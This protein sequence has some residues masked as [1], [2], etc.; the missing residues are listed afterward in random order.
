MK[1]SSFLFLALVLT[2]S[3]AAQQQLTLS[4][5]IL[6]ANSE[7]AP[8]RLKGLQWI[9]DSERYS[10]VKGDD[11]MRGAAT[12]ATP[13]RI[14]SLEELNRTLPDSLKLRGIPS[15]EWT[16][17]NTFRFLHKGSMY[18]YNTASAALN[19]Q[20]V[21]LAGAANEDVHAATGRVAFTVENDL[22]IAQPNSG[23]ASRVTNDGADGI[24]NGQSVHRQEYGIS[25]GTFWSHT[26]DL[27]AFYHMDETMVSI[28]RT[29]APSTPCATPWP[30][31]RATM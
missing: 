21:L 29:E 8:Q 22:F 26:G 7:L 5:A 16:S 6:K 11:L 4:D 25:K 2:A 31:R 17:A 18:S 10:F 13:E 20:A 15:I 3:L 30:A 27:L 12:D 14:L 28:Y 19:T 24:V 1:R 23:K 9:K